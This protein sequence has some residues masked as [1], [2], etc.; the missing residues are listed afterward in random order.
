MFYVNGL[1]HANEL[2]M[3][4]PTHRLMNKQHLLLALCVCPSKVNEAIALVTL[5]C[6]MC[7]NQEG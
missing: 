1:P 4:L 5:W 2:G 6:T 3:S 7:L